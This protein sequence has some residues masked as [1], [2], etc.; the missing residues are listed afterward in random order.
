MLQP[1]NSAL[2]TYMNLE[3][4]MIEAINNYLDLSSLLASDLT[5]ML[6]NEDASDGWKRNYIRVVAALIEGD[7]FCFREMSSIGL[8]CEFPA[9]TAKERKALESGIGFKAVE[10][11]KLVLRATY[12][13]FSLGEAPDFSGNE[14]SDANSF[15]NKRHAL[16]HPKSLTDLEIPSEEWAKIQSG[17]NWLIKQHF[18]ITRLI[19]E[20]YIKS[21]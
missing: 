5:E 14:W 1:L 2:A 15:Y 11:I 6:D 20:K 10:Q 7:S 13:M 19:H 3:T 12:K 21:S 18:D 9:I 4:R 16:M 8:L 17:A